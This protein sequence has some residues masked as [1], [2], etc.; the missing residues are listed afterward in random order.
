[1]LLNALTSTGLILQRTSEDDSEEPVPY[2]LGLAAIRP[3]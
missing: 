3:G 2:L 1:V